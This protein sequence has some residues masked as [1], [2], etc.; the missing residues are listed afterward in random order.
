MAGA[1]H[2]QAHIDD[3]HKFQKNR[4]ALEVIT[5]TGIQSHKLRSVSGNTGVITTD[6]KAM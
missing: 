6:S 1:A 4:D 2:A 5:N 3:G